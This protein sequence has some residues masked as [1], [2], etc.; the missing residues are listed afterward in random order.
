MSDTGE[1]LISEAQQKQFS[2]ARLARDSRFD[3]KFFVAVKSTGIFCR[4]ICP[5]RLPQEKNV[6][7]YRLS[8]EAMRDG[9]RPCLRCRPDSAPG[10]FAWLGVTTTVQRALTLLAAIPPQPVTIIAQRLGI[11]VRYLHKLMTT[12]LGIS[13]K[14][15]QVY[16]QLLFAKSLL[17]QSRIDV[18][19]VAVAAGFESP[20]RLQ[21]MMKK[22]WQLSPSMLRK[23][24][25]PL[26]VQPSAPVVTLQ[27]SYLPPY[28]WSFVRDFLLRR[29]ISGVEEISSSAYAR[30]FTYGVASGKVVATHCPDQQRFNVSLEISDLSQVRN[31]MANVARVLDVQA[32][33]DI[34]QQALARAGIPAAQQLTGIRLPGVW[35]EFEAGCRAIVGQQVSVKAAINAVNLLVSKLG[36]ITPFGTA[37]P[38]AAAVEA[39]ALEF[40][41]MP[42]ARRQALR[43]F[44]AT[45][46]EWDTQT[47]LTENAI[48]AIKG[49]GPWTRDY[50]MMR[51][52]SLPDVYLG[53]DLIAKR[54]AGAMALEP[55]AAAP[56]R[57]YLTLQLWELADRLQKEK[58]SN[59]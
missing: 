38:T 47:P 17:Q 13:P 21:D 35:S 3:G 34:I 9:Y 50:I 14:Q 12:H 10:S 41:K 22:Y 44:A 33:P 29:Q 24:H 4:P 48:L 53:T 31:V 59:V 5:A 28:D 52:H 8:L 25:S 49:V 26:A 54:M 2:E 30:V 45:V 39:H 43:L 7:Y 11:S 18:T 42:Q 56:W 6:A 58:I 20:R 15:I 37:F 55:E 1:L 16:H 57:S 40:L 32:N 23:S 46:A 36:E 51:G 27:L 19:S